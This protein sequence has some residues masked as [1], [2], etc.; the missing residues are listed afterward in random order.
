MIKHTIFVFIFTCFF[1]INAVKASGLADLRQALL[2]LQA[3]IPIQASLNIDATKKNGN[4]K[5]AEVLHSNIDLV[6]NSHQGNFQFNY[7]KS[8][9][10]IIKQE[11]K[12]RRKDNNV[13]TPTINAVSQINTIELHNM[14]SAG[15]NLI[16]YLDSLTFVEEKVVDHQEEKMRLL[17]FNIPMEAVVF[18]KK[19]RRYVDD[20]SGQYHIYINEEGLPQESTFEFYGRGRAYIVLTAKI[21]GHGREQYEVIDD[22]LVTLHSESSVTTETTFGDNEF[23]NIKRLTIID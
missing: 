4:G 11:Q 23:V 10:D 6:L 16:D 21:L 18:D 3:N 17:T 12:Q 19:F 13:N 8:L 15:E 1:L 7:D 20:F 2:P 5:D 9:L 14:L 22:R